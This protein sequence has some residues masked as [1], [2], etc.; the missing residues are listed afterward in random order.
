MSWNSPLDIQRLM[1][2]KKIL[3]HEL[4]EIIR[5]KL[6]LFCINTYLNINS[7]NLM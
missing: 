7:F 5:I 3:L 1:I 6:K 4:T 2:L